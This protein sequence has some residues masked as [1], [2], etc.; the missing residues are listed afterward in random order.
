MGLFKKELAFEKIELSKSKI[1]SDK[2]STIKV[3]VKN[4][5]DKVDNIIL[6]I[7]TDDQNNQYVTINNPVI[8]LSP[9]DFPDKNTG[10]HEITITPHNIPLSTMSFKITVEVFGNNREKP[11]LNK[12]FNLTVKKKT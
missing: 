5:K 6:K 7:K 11:I 1:D 3:N 10:E 8:R 9:L 12:E 4:F 2:T